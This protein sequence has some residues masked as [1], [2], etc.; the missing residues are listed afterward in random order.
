MLIFARYRPITCEHFLDYR[1]GGGYNFLIIRGLILLRSAGGGGG[2]AILK[3]HK[4]IKCEGLEM[5]RHRTGLL[6]KL[7][8]YIMI[9]ANLCFLQK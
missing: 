2:G 7:S 3:M 9:E 6:C 1:Q 5:L 8:N 4:I